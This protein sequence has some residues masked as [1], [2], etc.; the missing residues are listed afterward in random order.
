[1]PKRFYQSNKL[2]P[3]VDILT[4]LIL[5][6]SVTK[7]MVAVVK[8][9]HVLVSMQNFN[10]SITCT[11]LSCNAQVVNYVRMHSACTY[12]PSVRIIYLYNLYAAVFY[13]YYFYY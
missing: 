5:I 3:L 2:P 8:F 4:S 13:Q 6:C 11:C 10:L 1:M 9:I 12:I 7:Y